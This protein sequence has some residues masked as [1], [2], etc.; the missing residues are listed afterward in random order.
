LI[1]VTNCRGFRANVVV[2]GDSFDEAKA[3]ARRLMEE[4]RLVYVHGFDDADIISGQG[5]MGLEILEDVPDVDA[6]IVPV[7]GGGLIA[8]VGT[9]I[10]AQKPSVRIVGVEPQNAPTLYESLKA[11]EVLRIPTKPTPADRLAIAEPG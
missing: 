7:G 4:Q 6:V 8:G 5:T 10:K 11:G 3:H 2:H 1:K 9:A